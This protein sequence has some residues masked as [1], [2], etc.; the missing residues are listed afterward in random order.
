M[1][2][3]DRRK[4]HQ[5]IRESYTELTYNPVAFMCGEESYLIAGY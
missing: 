4:S 1:A 2:S 3:I 5:G